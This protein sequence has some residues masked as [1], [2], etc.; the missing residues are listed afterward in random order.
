[1]NLHTVPRNHMDDKQIDLALNEF[2]RRWR[3]RTPAIRVQDVLPNYRVSM[4]EIHS[5]LSDQ[6]IDTNWLKLDDR[7]MQGVEMVLEKLQKEFPT[8]NWE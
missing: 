3:S 1:M 4:S 2:E 7:W 6:G 8:E 5:W